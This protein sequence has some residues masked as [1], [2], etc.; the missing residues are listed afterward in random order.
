MA[1]KKRILYEIILQ[2]NVLTSM[3]IHKE[4]TAK[5]LHTTH[6]VYATLQ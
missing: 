1:V 2:H 4:V 6:E 3:D 5:R